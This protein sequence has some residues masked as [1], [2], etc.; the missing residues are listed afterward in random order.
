MEHHLKITLIDAQTGEGIK[1][2]FGETCEA[3]LTTKGDL[4]RQIS[5]IKM[6]RTMFPGISLK[7]A[8]E[9]TD[10][11]KFFMNKEFNLM[12]REE[13]IKARITNMMNSLNLEEL[14]DLEKISSFLVSETPHREGFK[15][16]MEEKNKPILIKEPDP[17]LLKLL[18][19]D[20]EEQYHT[21]DMEPCRHKCEHTGCENY[22]TYHDEPYCFYH[23]P[24]SGSSFK[25]YDSRKGGWQ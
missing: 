15:E 9:F 24:D 3:V 17:E 18:D 6:I 8:K 23:S 7:E 19:E 21:C 22:I 1:D 16:F 10:E 11:F 13:T 2:V 12:N 4:L 5:F 20:E 14:R 25:N